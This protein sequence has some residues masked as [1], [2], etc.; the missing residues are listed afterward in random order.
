MEVGNKRSKKPTN[1][2]VLHSFQFH[3]GFAPL[4]YSLASLWLQNMQISQKQIICQT[5][6]IHAFQMRMVNI[7]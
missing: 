2:K 7:H 5:K 6:Q 3:L 1:E 4:I